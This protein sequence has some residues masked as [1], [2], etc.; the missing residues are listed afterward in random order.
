MNVAES[1][2]CAVERLESVSSKAALHWS[3]VGR[4][5]RQ[6]SALGPCTATIIHEPFYS[7]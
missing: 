7:W 4:Y 3:H 6:D 5:K 2:A 1:F